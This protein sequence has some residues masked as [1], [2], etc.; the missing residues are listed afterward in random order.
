ME[1]HDP[2]SL[3]DSEDEDAKKKDLKPED[4]DRLKQAAAEAMSDSITSPGDKKLEPQDKSES[5][6]IRDKKIE[7]I[8]EKP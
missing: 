2:F 5:T 3:G 8:V 7:E 6:D 1:D 4:S